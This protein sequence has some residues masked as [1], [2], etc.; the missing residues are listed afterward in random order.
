VQLLGCGLLFLE[1][2]EEFCRIFVVCVLYVGI[3]EYMED[4][5]CF[6]FGL[7]YFPCVFVFELFKRGR[8]KWQTYRIVAELKPFAYV[9]GGVKGESECIICLQS[10]REKERLVRLRCSDFHHF[11]EEC[12]RQWVGT[13]SSCPACRALIQGA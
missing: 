7:V 13:A 4:Y 10:Y 11:H 8:E 3:Y 6:A 2:T 9:R 5:L 1:S 12:L